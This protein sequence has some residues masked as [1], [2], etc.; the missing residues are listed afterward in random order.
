[1]TWDLF[2][3][4]ARSSQGILDTP[5]GP[6]PL[7]YS[8][9]HMVNLFRF[10][11]SNADVEHLGQCDPCADWADNYSRSP[12]ALAARAHSQS[13]F[14]QRLSGWLGAEMSADI[15]T[16]MVHVAHPL[17]G[18]MTPGASLDLALVAGVNEPTALDAGSLRLEGKLYCN[19]ATLQTRVL[20]GRTYAV[21]HFSG[22]R[23][24]ESLRQDVQNH[25]SVTEDVEITGRIT[26]GGTFR[27]RAHVQIA[28]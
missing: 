20:A 5:L 4:M 27:G 22:V 18:V 26:G 21:V 7:C 16:P 6:T 3:E 1:M 17:V 28:K 9:R 23:M 12:S 11:A 15:L 19:Q 13:T 24:K 2:G 8:P 25:V 10:G 14:R